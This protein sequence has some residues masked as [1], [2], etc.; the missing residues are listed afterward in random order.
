MSIL[1]LGG[2]ASGLAAAISAAQRGADV[3][4]C[5][6]AARVGRKLLA[7]GN[8]RCNVSNEAI[9]PRA[10]HG[11]PA[12]LDAVFDALPPQA[13]REFLQDLGLV[14]AGEDGRLYP[15]SFAAASV[16]DT[17]RL[18]LERLNVRIAADRCVTAIA[19]SRKGGFSVSFADGTSLR[20]A[21][22]IC[23]LG[24]KAAPHLGTDGSGLDM[25]RALG[26]RIT[27][28]YPALVQLRCT[29]G[30]LKAL[31]GVRVRAK[32]TL[33]RSRSGEISETGE[34]LFTDYGVSGVAVFQLSRHAALALD[35]GEQVQLSLDLWQALTPSVLQRRAALF[36]AQSTDSLFTGVF[37]RLLGQAILHQAHIAEQPCGALS[38]AQLDAICRA[39]HDFTL[40]VTGTQSFE[41]A[42][43]TA[44]GVDTREIDPHTF[45]SRLYPGLF[46]TGEAVDVDGPCGGF[47]LH[48]AFTGGI[49][50]GRAAAERSKA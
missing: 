9:T 25:L 8:G 12:F 1:I 34:L 38:S 31:K 50:A 30:A 15:H 35:H 4:I 37:H 19:P 33:R 20:A 3:C 46:I 21:Q 39:V 47:N 45:E 11:D 26:H 42:Q 23:A 32:M 13:A 17:L 27:P 24:G 48:F 18:A 43:V 2:G 29:H 16:L 40:P 36:G 6:R 5:E 28:L 10:Y 41:Q 22:V 7:S 49:L 14:F 44:G